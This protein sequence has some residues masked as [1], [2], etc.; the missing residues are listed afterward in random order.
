M[1]AEFNEKKEFDWSLLDS[2]DSDEDLED[3][4]EDEDVG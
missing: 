1:K 3:G 2:D 4:K